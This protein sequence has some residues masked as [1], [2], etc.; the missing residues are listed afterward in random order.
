MSNVVVV[1]QV[2]NQLVITAQPAKLLDIVS[3]AGIKGDKG[4][5]GGGSIVSLSYI[6]D[7]NGSVLP[8]GNQGFLEIPF[9]CTIQQVTLL[10][11]VTGNIVVDI[12]KDTYATFPLSLSDSIVASAKPTLSNANKYQDSVLTGWIKTI[13]AGEVL[14]FNI[15]S[16]SNITYILI[17]LKVEKT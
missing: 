7:N 16:V 13:T 10:A 17:S 9:A 15:D 5:T 3:N 2:A 1:T 14:Q 11:D 4:D 12:W 6:V 8:T